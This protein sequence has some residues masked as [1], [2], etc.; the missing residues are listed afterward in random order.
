MTLPDSP[1]A[2]RERFEVIDAL[3][4]FAL[5]GVLLIN[6][7]SLALYGLLPRGERDALA[8]LPIDRWLAWFSDTFV[9]G[10]AIT[11][12]SLLFGVGFALQIRR[13]PE[14]P[15]VVRRYLRR[16]LVLLG[17]GLLHALLWWGDILRY[18]ALLGVL[19]VPMWR[20]RARTLVWAG[21][22]L[23]VL[24]PL[25]MQPWLP[26]LLPRQISNAESAARTLVA[27]VGS[28]WGSAFQANVERD[29]RMRIA[30]WMLPTYVLGRLMIGM[31][32]GRSGVLQ[33]APNHTRFWKRLLSAMA[34]CAALIL[35]ATELR[36]SG[37]FWPE[38]RPGALLGHALR[39]ALPLCLGL[40]Y[41][42]G[43]VLLYL[44]P[45]ARRGLAWLA[46]VGRMALT[47]YLGQT[48]IAI[49]LF[50]GIGL[51]LGPVSPAGIATTAIVVFAIQAVTSAWWLAHHR[52]GPMEWLWR[53]LTYGPFASPGTLARPS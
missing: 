10:T 8:S 32:L 5:F 27:F 6:L 19:L 7:Q 42:A 26:A 48:L 13:G 34:I 44:N 18:Y 9:S 49:A 38:G 1:T 21:V 47:N 53:R 46:P 52:H 17:I 39:N 31:A 40:G 14:D 29:L 33:D 35:L 20:V 23:V 15:A 3:R 2:A 12:F 16:L 50:Y 30:V 51:G 37:H 45:I 25:L 24:M 22:L 11:L 36:S 28:D 4:G 41:M 43:F